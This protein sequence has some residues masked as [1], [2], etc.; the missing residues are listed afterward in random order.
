MITQPFT[1]IWFPS[2]PDQK[3]ACVPYEQYLVILNKLRRKLLR[4]DSK[5]PF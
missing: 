4:V 3:M 1:H 5:F 2:A